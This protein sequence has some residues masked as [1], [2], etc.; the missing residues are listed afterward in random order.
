VHFKPIHGDHAIL[1]VVFQVALGRPLMRPDIESLTAA[2]RALAA[3][4]PSARII[5]QVQPVGDVPVSGAP[6]MQSFPPKQ[7][8]PCQR[9]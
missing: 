8:C 3:E 7:D 5:Q 1:E 6:A 9:E 2:H 4:L